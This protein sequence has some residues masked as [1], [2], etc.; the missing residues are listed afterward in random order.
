MVVAEDVAAPAVRPASADATP[1][2]TG[3]SSDVLTQQDAPSGGTRTFPAGT[4][5]IRMD[6]PYARIADALLDYQYWA[7]NDPQKRPYDDT[8]WTFPEGFGTQAIRIVDTTVL[9]TPMVPVTGDVTP[10]GGVSGSGTTFAVN[11]DANPALITLRYQIKG[12][13][14]QAAEQAFDANGQHFNRGSFVIRNIQSA[15][16]DK[17]A[18]PLGIKAVA[19]SA[20]PSVPMHPVRAPRVAIV[21]SW[22]NTQTEGWWREAFDFQKVP[23]DYIGLGELA[24]I[25]NISSVYDVIVLTPG[26]GNAQTMVAGTS[27]WSAPVAW[28]HSAEMPNIGTWAETDNINAGLGWD[29]V[30][31]LQDFVK[32]GGVLIS[33]MNT[34]QFAIDFGFTYGVSDAPATSRVVGTLLRTQIGDATSPIL[35]G[36]TDNLAMFSETGESFGVSNMRVLPGAGGGRGAGGGGGGGGGGHGGGRGGGAGPS[37]ETGRGTPDDPD[38]V[39]GRPNFDPNAPVPGGF[40][41]SASVAGAAGGRGGGRGGGGN[42]IPADQQPR[43]ILHFTADQSHLLVSRASRWWIGVGRSAGGRRSAVR[44]G[45]VVLF[46]TNPMYRGETIGSYPLVF[47]TILNFDNLSA[48]RR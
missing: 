10:A 20:A 42:A 26:G 8:G 46:A 7:P 45:H 44:E 21:H 22:T 47:N 48:G 29:G 14:I 16:L 34:A 31:R 11:A 1:A 35:Y 12:A 4:Y 15:D 30:I 5:I 27:A 41:D 6:Q 24:K 33:T 2:T 17:V 39:Q 40:G 37:R 43:N 19:L 13:D 23:Y 18:K 9:N 3:A 36:M 32:R 38:V 28:K 25:P